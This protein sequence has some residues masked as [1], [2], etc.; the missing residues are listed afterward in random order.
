ML[1]NVYRKIQ[2]LKTMLELTKGR[3]F[4][5][6]F[7]VFLFASG[8]YFM[9][10]N[11]TYAQ[12]GADL[13]GSIIDVCQT[14]VDST[15]QKIA[16]ATV[17]SDAQTTNMNSAVANLINIYTTM[18]GTESV[19]PCEGSSS[20]AAAA[21][22]SISRNGLVGTTHNAMAVLML[23][24]PTQDVANHLYVEWI[25]GAS[26][27][28]ANSVYAAESG[29]DYLLTTGISGLWEKVRNIAYVLFIIVLIAAGFMIMFRHK[30]GGQVAVTVMSTIPNVVVSL[31]LVT[32]SFA[33][34]GLIMNLGGILVNV[35][36]GVL[37]LGTDKVII[38]N[39]FSVFG[40]FFK[41][42]TGGGAA[43]GTLLT[44]AVTALA[45]NAG[46]GALTAASVTGAL[47]VIAGAVVLAGIIAVIL[48][49]IVL[50]VVLWASFKVFS[51]LLKAY[52]GLLMDTI[53]APLY[54]LISAIPGQEQ[55]RT[56]WF[57]RVLKNVLVFPVV[58]FF[59][60]IGTYLVKNVDSLALP[61]GLTG[62]AAN[63]DIA[64]WLTALLIRVFIVYLYF[65][66]AEAPKFI[67]DFLPTN[68]GKGMADA[69]KSA[70]SSIP[71]I[72]GM[73]G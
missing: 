48:G 50:G 47:P 63:Q 9:F 20:A 11:L 5:I 62:G 4:K 67:E 49:I 24:P 30:I 69:A 32:F 26:E 34:V 27:N 36:G 16:T 53:L 52:A 18:A 12:T 40:A 1:L 60:N 59:V 35:L 8:V 43:S 66:A 64:D 38:D 46:L 2:K 14:Y 13:S 21:L 70:A 44:G 65:L 42:D 3:R 25:P 41:G 39:F 61:S 68:G 73:F 23:N 29:Y 10:G 33:I 51:T 28:S 17:N 15:N 57:N 45:G 22:P 55:K 56:D 7:N 37:E 31:L 58:F 19:K 72:G 71:L 54:L 6:L